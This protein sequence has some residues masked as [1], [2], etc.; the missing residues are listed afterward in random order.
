MYFARYSGGDCSTRDRPRGGDRAGSVGGTQL[1]GDGLGTRVPV[2]MEHGSAQLRERWEPIASPSICDAN[3]RVHAQRQ[4]CPRAPA[5]RP[6]G[7][8]TGPDAPP[9]RCEGVLICTYREAGSLHT[10]RPGMYHTHQRQRSAIKL[11][12]RF[13]TPFC[14][15]MFPVCVVFPS[16]KF[17]LFAPSESMKAAK[18]VEICF[19]SMNCVGPNPQGCPLL[20]LFQYLFPFA[21]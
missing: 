7:R 1:G 8:Q 18:I 4:W 3:E 20:C 12:G 21:S 10:T 17:A 5:M 2:P 16:W 14:R 6:E 13:C 15:V 9:S 11:A 19:A